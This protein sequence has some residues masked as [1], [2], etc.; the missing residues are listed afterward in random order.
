MV[1]AQDSEAA[2]AYIRCIRNSDKRD[3][4]Y[5]WFDYL[6]GFRD[7]GPTC[8]Q[9]GIT[10]MAAQAVRMRLSQFLKIER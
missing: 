10:Y 3:F 8:N 9:F 6:L 5:A 4:A 1:A 7:D 2:L